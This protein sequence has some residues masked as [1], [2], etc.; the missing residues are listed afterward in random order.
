MG[1]LMTECWAHTP[2]SRL[3]A[4][5][6]KKD[7]CQ[8]V[9][10]AGTSSCEQVCLHKRRKGSYCHTGSGPG[11]TILEKEEEQEADHH[12]EIAGIHTL[13]VQM[14]RTR[15]CRSPFERMYNRITLFCLSEKMSHFHFRLV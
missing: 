5:R 8:D 13:R 1:K 14:H 15:E 10:I 6:V 4:L 12:L 2:G 11:C 3:T 9:R 7:P